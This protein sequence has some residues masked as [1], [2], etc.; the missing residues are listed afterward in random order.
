M[1]EFRLKLPNK[2]EYDKNKIINLNNLF[3]KLNNLSQIKVL[4]LEFKDCIQ[5]FFQIFS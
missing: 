5:L 2:I 3:C 4:K 1:K